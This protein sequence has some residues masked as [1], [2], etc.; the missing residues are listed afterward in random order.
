MKQAYKNCTKDSQ[1]LLAVEASLSVSI[2]SKN[3]LHLWPVSR[4]SNRTRPA[5]C[6]INY[7]MFY[8]LHKV[9]R[10]FF[11]TLTYLILHKIYAFFTTQFLYN[12]DGLCNT[13]QYIVV[14]PVK[15][16]ILYQLALI[17]CSEDSFL[18]NKRP[19]DCYPAQTSVW[20]CGA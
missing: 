12:W 6:N 11:T 10:N 16:D 15:D 5:V 13:F 2:H 1:N 17:I 9:L 14:H 18:N 7:W 8:C 19:V 3:T 4:A 20:L